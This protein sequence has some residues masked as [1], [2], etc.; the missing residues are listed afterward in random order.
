MQ[1]Y[2]T[3]VQTILELHQ[4]C[5]ELFLEGYTGDNYGK[6]ASSMYLRAVSSTPDRKNIC[7][8]GQ[9]L[10]TQKEFHFE[11]SLEKYPTVIRQH[12]NNLTK[13]FNW[14][15]IV[16]NEKDVRLNYWKLYLLGIKCGTVSELERKVKD[17]DELIYTKIK[18][19]LDYLDLPTNKN[20]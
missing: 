4:K 20:V 13:G 18:P 7:F 5:K 14:I 10:V 9:N 17:H 8:D 19:A 1:E 6:D 12:L 11:F 2:A 15:N 16:R 3:L